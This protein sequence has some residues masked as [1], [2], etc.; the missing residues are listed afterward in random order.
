MK[1]IIQ[2]KAPYNSEFGQLTTAKISSWKSI[3]SIW[4]LVELCYSVDVEFLNQ[5]F[6]LLACI[7]VVHICMHIVHTQFNQRPPPPHHQGLESGG[8]G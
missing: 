2:T 6:E 3:F 7:Y 4:S 5:I 1:H 8:N